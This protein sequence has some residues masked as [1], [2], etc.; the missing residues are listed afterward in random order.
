[1]NKSYTYIGVAL[2]LCLTACDMF[3]TFPEGGT[4]TSEQKS[5]AFASNPSTSTADVNGIYA[6]MI[7]L[8]AGIGETYSNHNDFGVAAQLIA[9]ESNGQDFIAPNIGYNWFSYNYDWKDRDYSS[10]DALQMWSVFYKIIFA[11]NNALQAL[12]PAVISGEALY[13]YGQAKAARAYAYLNMAQIYQFTYS[14]ENKDKPCV[15]IITEKTTTDQQLNN[16]R[17]SLDSVYSLILGD[18]TDAISALNGYARSDKGHINQAVAYGIRARAYLAMKEYAAAAADA[19]MCLNLSGATPY[20]LSEVSKPNF[21]TADANSVI[22]ANIITESN[23]IVLS[24]I[25]NWPSHLS[26]F[27][28]DGYTGVGATRSIPKA[29]YSKIPNGDVRKGWWLNANGESALLNNSNYQSY[30]T[31]FSAANAYTNV[32]FGVV[33]D[34]TSTLSAAADWI[35]MR[36]EE[37]LLI[38][39]EGL[40]MSGNIAGAKTILEQFVQNY[41][42]SGYTCKASSDTDLQDE[43]W[44]QRRI[45]LWGEGFAFFDIMRL[46]KSIVREKG[47]GAGYYPAAWQYTIPA[48]SDI[49]LWMIPQSEIEANDGISDSDNNP[50]AAQ[51]VA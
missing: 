21:C 28:T 25:I 19:D 7:A 3:N 51:P 13:N 10:T 20:T 4:K 43:I 36:S 33:N 30:K 46:E 41:R 17:A 45:E 1:M 15:P 47:E 29:L 35:L 32:K 8:Y 11:A 2:T 18:L 27:Y 9:L 39:A 40:A 26:T 6:Q 23:D 37:M 22:W 16:P 48:K 42:Y 34:N 50:K 5:E 14:D 24:S 31:S 12:D 44:L 49:L 38:K